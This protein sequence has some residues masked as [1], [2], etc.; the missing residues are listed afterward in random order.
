MRKMRKKKSFGMTVRH[1]M[2]RDIF[3]KKYL[4]LKLN[5]RSCEDALVD[6]NIAIFKVFVANN[7]FLLV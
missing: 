4:M 6:K 5:V 1:V 3:E 7:I 2:T